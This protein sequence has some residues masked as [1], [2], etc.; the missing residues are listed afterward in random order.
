MICNAEDGIC[1]AGVFGGIKSGVHEKTKHVFLESACFESGHI[2]RT[3]KHHGLKTDAS[4]R[5]ERGSD[6]EI[7]VFALKRAATMIREIAG[8]KISSE[9]VDVYPFPV[10]WTEIK[11]SYANIDALIGKSIDHK[12]IKTILTALGIKIISENTEGLNISVP[13]F[14]VDVKREADVIEEILRIYGYNNVEVPESVRLSLNYGEKPDKDRMQNMVSDYLSNNGFYEIMCNS[15]TKSQYYLNSSIFDEKHGVRILNPLSKELDVMRQTLLFGGLETIAYNQNRKASDLK[16][17]E[18]GNT[19]HYNANREGLK[20]YTE[21]AHLALFVSGRKQ[22]ESWYNQEEKSDIY[23]L[24]SFVD[25][26]FKK[27]GIDISLFNAE[28]FEN[29]IFSEGMQYKKNNEIIAELGMIGQQVLARSDIKQPVFYSDINWSFLMKHVKADNIKFRELPK[30]PEVR[31]DLALLLDKKISFAEIEKLAY[32]TEKKYLRSVGLF[33]VYEGD[34]IEAGKKSYAVSFVLQD[35]ETTLTD[36]R[37]EKIMNKMM[38]A[39]SEKLG[40]II[41]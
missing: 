39:Y 14:K 41:R 4:F 17:Y 2:R 7:T 3:S 34:K 18:F 16:M 20:K 1:I 24:K 15:L 30:F 38:I 19:Y 13:P 6:P 9:I 21:Y 28:P 23:L 37:I 8:G 25:A 33:D 31:R 36:E 11:I 27:A 40:A 5:F 12:T 29:E 10:L 22:P 32:A 35:F 26:V